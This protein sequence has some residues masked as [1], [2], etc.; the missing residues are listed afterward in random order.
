MRPNYITY[1]SGVGLVIL[2]TFFAMLVS[3]KYSVIEYFLVSLALAISVMI[4]RRMKVV[5]PVN[6]LFSSLVVMVSIFKI[7]EASLP[8]LL[9]GEILISRR[10]LAV[11][12]SLIPVVTTDVYWNFKG[13][14]A[15]T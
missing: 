8:T 12:V 2:P 14:R 15:Q 6:L 1:I 3:L 9:F 7:F 4:A 11:G 5:G 13:A 10:V